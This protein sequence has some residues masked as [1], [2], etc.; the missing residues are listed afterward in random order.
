MA[1]CDLNFDGF[2]KD[3]WGC[4]DILNWILNGNW[5]KRF[6]QNDEIVAFDKVSRKIY[7]KSFLNRNEFPISLNSKVFES[8]S[9]RL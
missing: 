2:L 9:S 7:L 4:E 5:W 6:D 1:F 3:Y 8:F